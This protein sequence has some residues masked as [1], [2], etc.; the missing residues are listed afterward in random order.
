MNALCN[1]LHLNYFYV[2]TAYGSLDNPKLTYT[3]N[4]KLE[5]GSNKISILSVSVGMP[6]VGEHFETWNAGVL[7]PVMLNGLNE[8]RKDLT[9]QKWSY[10][11]GL[12]G[13]ELQLHSLGGSSNVEWGISSQNQTLAWYKALFSAP[14][15]NEPLALDMG[16]MGKGQVWINGHNIGRYWPAYK[17]YGTCS[18][19]DYRGEYSETKCQTNCGEA[20]QR[21]YHVPREWLYPT[22][23]LIVVLEEIGGD[24]NGISIVKRSIGR[25]CVDI[26]EWQ[27][28]MKN[29]HTKDYER[30]KIHLSC[31]PGQ[32]ITKINFASFGTPSGTCG[33]FSEGKCHS[34]ESYDP[35]E[36]KCIGQ[37]S[38]AVVIEPKVFGGDP[39]PGI[40]KRIAVEAICE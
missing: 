38:C 6:N 4:I 40:M 3:G 29:W 33:S 35:F 31:N 28:S 17:A 14:D 39:C 23:N 11:I 18:D 7:G 30:S 36:M 2:G 21:W 24:P 20:S 26:S 8:G 1:L 13:E 27:P 37:E 10:Q 34:H 15:G 9:W 22:G 16:S 19:C 32:K 25:A 12:K 5:A